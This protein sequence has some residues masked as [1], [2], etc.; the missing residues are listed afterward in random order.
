MLPPTHKSK[1]RN[2]SWTPVN[3]SSHCIRTTHIHVELTSPQAGERANSPLELF[4]SDWAD[5]SP[6]PAS[7]LPPACLLPTEPRCTTTH[8]MFNNVFLFLFITV[9]LYIYMYLCAFTSVAIALVL[10]VGQISPSFVVLY[11]DLGSI[12]SFPSSSTM[13]NSQPLSYL[14]STFLHTESSRNAMIDRTIS[15]DFRIET[16]FAYPRP[17][18]YV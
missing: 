4:P 2:G 9:L 17:P 18:R 1:S 13:T 11:I 12:C 16:A 14:P 7:C 5:G 3:Y 15:P 8:T 10:P 6:V